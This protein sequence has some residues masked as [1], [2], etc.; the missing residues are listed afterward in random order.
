MRL[1]GGALI[2]QR[3]FI[4]VPGAATFGW[5]PFSKKTAS[6]Y[7]TRYEASSSSVMTIWTPNFAPIP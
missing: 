3:K 2:T 1:S 4:P 7:L 6:P 5:Y